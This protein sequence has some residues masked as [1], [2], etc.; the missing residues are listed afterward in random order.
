LSDRIIYLFI[1]QFMTYYT[2][3]YNDNVQLVA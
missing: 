3:Y 1:F 2:L